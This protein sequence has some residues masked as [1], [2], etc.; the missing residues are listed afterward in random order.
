MRSIPERLFFSMGF[1]ITVFVVVLSRPIEK[2]DENFEGLIT[3]GAA[4]NFAGSYK[5]VNDFNVEKSIEVA[6]L[7]AEEEKRIA[8][9]ERKKA[10]E[11]KR[12]T[13]V[14]KNMTTNELITLIN[15]SLYSDIANKGELIVTHCLERGVDPITATAIMLQETGCK[16]GCSALV[17]KCH[18]V[19]GVVGSP[20]CSGAFRGYDSL[21]SGIKLFIDNLAYN[22]YA[23]GYDTPEKMNPTY[24]ESKEWAQYVNNYIVEI[25]SKK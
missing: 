24:A 18:N 8:E 17:K 20:A 21:D 1:L 3:Q 9:E 11:E 10:E 19:G 25:L 23:R 4:S 16:W 22:F 5:D 13:V 14:Y 15:K 7:K 6:R 2:N 12:N